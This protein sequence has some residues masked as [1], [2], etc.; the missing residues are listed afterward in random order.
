MREILRIR[1]G[2]QDDRKDDMLRDYQLRVFAGDIFYI[3][4]M[5]GSGVGTL[6]SLLAGECALKQGEFL[7][8]EKRVENFARNT[9]YQYGIYTITAEKDLV[10]TLTVAENL[11]AVRYLPFPGRRYDP[12]RAEKKVEEYLQKEQVDI[13]ARAFLWMLS[14]KERQKLSI[15]KAKMHGARLIVLDATSDVYEG[16]EA[17]ELCALIQRANAEG[18]TFVILSECYAMFAEI[19]NRIQIISQGRDLKEWSGLTER[20]QK[21]LH[22]E[23]IA[24]QDYRKLKGVSLPFLGMFDYEWEMKGC[25]WDYL[26]YVKKHN[27]EIWKQ[28]IGADI[29]DTGFSQKKNTVVIPKDSAEYLLK[30][31]SIADNLI[32]PIPLRVGKKRFGV[33]KKRIR[34]NIAGGFYKRIGLDSDITHIEELNRIQKKLLSIY[35]FELNRP[36]V[37]ILE[38]PYSGMNREERGI[39]RSYLTALENKGIRIVYFS[40]SREEIREDCHSVVVT[41]NGRSAKITTF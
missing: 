23:M 7:V 19:A 12:R 34:E 13:P 31:L 27:P 16:Q 29:P 17:E 40:K 14:K 5:E 4:G 41:Q 37:M 32:M 24:E 26:T 33:I 18:I 28:Y 2:M 6:I 21:R 20:V 30:N 25:I 36:R 1:H 9:A 11:E 38:S 22:H 39:L 35:R 3:Q 10:E 15:L 8:D